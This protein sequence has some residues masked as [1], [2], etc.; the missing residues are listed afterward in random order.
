MSQNSAA[1]TWWN[2]IPVFFTALNY[3]IRYN[4]AATLALV[5]WL[6]DKC[7]ACNQYC[8]RGR[9]DALI[10]AC[11]EHKHRTAKKNSNTFVSLSRNVSSFYAFIAHLFHRLLYCPCCCC[12]CWL[13]CANIYRRVSGTSVTPI[14]I[15]GTTE[16]I[17]YARNCQPLT[18]TNNNKEN[19]CFAYQPCDSQATDWKTHNTMHNFRLVVFFFLSLVSSSCCCLANVFERTYAS[20]V[21][22]PANWIRL[23]FC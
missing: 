18:R 6:A 20:P 5:S 17:W 2:D 12:C 15:F 22:M 13:A 7:T 19:I 16:N 3:A 1:R 21:A 9:C 8:S 11:D 4:C 23:A 14:I 10:A